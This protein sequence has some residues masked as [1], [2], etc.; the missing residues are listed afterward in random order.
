[1]H[2]EHHRHDHEFP[3]AGHE[4]LHIRIAIPC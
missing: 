1:V 2:D 4:P 3:W